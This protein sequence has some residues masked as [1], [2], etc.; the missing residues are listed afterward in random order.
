VNLPVLVVGVGRPSFGDD[1]L[2]LVVADRLK[3]RLTDVARVIIDASGGW[4]ML[5]AIEDEELLILID[6]A[7]EN[8]R[9]RAGC[10]LRLDY[11]N[12]IGAIVDHKLRDTHTL[13]VASMLRIGQTLGRLPAD[14]W[15]YV[16]A[17]HDHHGNIRLLLPQLL[18]ELD[19]VH[20]RHLDVQQNADVIPLRGPI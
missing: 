6:A 14:V 3:E 2:G 5:D 18:K 12:A 20:L 9:L 10:W 1:A 13:S 16:I 7:E 19:P 11:P 17:G 15:I 4:E 8:E